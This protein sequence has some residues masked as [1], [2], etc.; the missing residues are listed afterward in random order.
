MEQLLHRVPSLGNA[1]LDRLCNGPEAFSPD[2]KWIVGETP[3]IRNYLVAAG[4]KTI[5][6]AAAG[7]VG[8]ATAELIVTGDTDFDMYELEVSRFL[9]LHNNRK[10][11]RDR[12]REVPGLHYGIMY[13]FHEFQTNT[14]NPHD[15]CTPYRMAYTNT[16]AKPPWFDCVAKEYEACRERVGLADYSSFTKIDLWSEGNEVVDALQYVCSNDVD[17]PVGSII[18]TGMQNKHGG[19]ENDCSLARLAEN[20]QDPALARK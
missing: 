14:E 20:Q 19:Y 7:G 12:V 5:G 18:H 4:M 15:W 3:E 6:I 13:P 16:F 1:V 11:L 17:V 2:C 10:F 9:G 8:K